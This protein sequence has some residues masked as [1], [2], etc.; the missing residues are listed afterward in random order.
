L[1]FDL[2]LRI[3]NLNKQK[4]YFSSSKQK[5][6]YFNLDPILKESINWKI[7]EKN[8]DEVVKHMV[9]LKTNIVEQDHRGIKRIIKSMMGFKAFHSAEAAIAGIEL[10]RMLKKGQHVNSG[11]GF[12][13]K[14]FLLISS[15]SYVQGK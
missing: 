5:N 9:A 3:K 8:Y 4:L 11:N 2:L 15:Y 12:A 7:F 13:F 6:D 10:C 14:Q 1:H